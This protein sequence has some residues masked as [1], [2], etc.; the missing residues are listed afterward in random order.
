MS[1]V[2]QQEYLSIGGNR[3]SSASTW[4]ARL[5][6]LAYGADCNVALWRPLDKSKNGVQRLYKAHNDKVTAV[7]SQ[8]TSQ[9]LLLSGAASGDLTLWSLNSELECRAESSISSAHDGA[10]NTLS[11]CESS[12]FCV[13]GGAD[14][15]I[16]LWRHQGFKLELM[17]AIKPKPRFIPLAIA[18][19]TFPGLSP[20]QG[21]FIAAAG[22]RN[23]ILIYAI[24]DIAGTP[25]TTLA[26]S[27]TGHEGWIRSLSLA[28]TVHGDYILASTSAD[29]YVR[30]WRFQSST[31]DERGTKS[32]VQEAISIE[33]TLTAKI[34]TVS[35]ADRSYSISFEALLLGHDDWVYAADWQDTAEP[36][37]LTASADGTLAIWEPDPTSGIWV[38]ETRLGEISGQKGA[39]TAT[40][41]SGGFWKGLWVSDEH[42]TAVVSLGRTG[43]WRMWY[44]DK[45]TSF[46]N[47]QP[48]VGGHTDSVNGLS[49]P[50]NGIC[51]AYLLSTSSDQT[52][53]LHAEWVREETSTWHEFSRCQ[54]HGYNCNVVS[55]INDHQFVSGADEK[56][57]RVFNEPK[58]LAD[59]LHHLCRL[60]L[61]EEYKMLPETAA[62]P[63]LGLSNKEMGEPDDIIE[64]GP[65]RGEDDYAAAQALAGISLR[66]IN[67]PP[68][69]DLLSR[70]TLWPE[71][72]KLYGHGYEISECAFGHGLLATACKASSIDHAT[73]RL[74]DAQKN[75]HQVEPPITAHSL[76]IT[77]LTWSASKQLLS[78]G[79]DRQWTVFQL[80]DDKQLSLVQAMPKAH[81]RMILDAAW[82]PLREANLFV[83]AGRDKTVKFWHH[84]QAAHDPDRDANEKVLKEDQFEHIKTITRQSPVTA[85]SLICGSSEKKALLAV[86]EEDGS[87]SLHVFDIDALQIQKSI[88]LDTSLCLPK[89]VTK[90]AWRPA[91]ASCSE[92]NSKSTEERSKPASG[93]WQLAIA[94][95]DGSVRIL[96]FDTQLLC[97]ILDY[98]LT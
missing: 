1:I 92:G 14:T 3:N 11:F 13:S 23:D 48:G 43:S 76:T 40:G 64:A 17:V 90:L 18:A 93:R 62:I 42:T 21:L 19:G 88:E 2:P 55:C 70:H 91:A 24:A 36:K 69:E 22:T 85:V 27:L 54:I 75:W 20:E 25:S 32:I 26:C 71:H 87:L 4:L 7:A 94:G 50:E 31:T 12:S 56:L 59:T 63:V 51:G 73:I 72:E 39:T 96:G 60:P 97:E 37:L 78:V 8:N 15:F 35:I 77:R 9:D 83:T 28:K 79:R 5:K 46:W 98:D 68:T 84:S 95:A 61:T 47:L 29:K 86:G 53:R 45:T 52:T 66:G 49:W 10:I 89:T 82:C 58:E 34:K 57:L 74:Y 41:S 81:S 80:N 38:S 30:L 16:K 44:F 6:C 67:Q 33:Q 65:R